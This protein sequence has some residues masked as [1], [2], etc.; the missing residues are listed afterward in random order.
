MTH[1]H[2]LNTAQ[3]LTLAQLDFWE[4]FRL[5]PGEAVSTVAHALELCGPVD[6]DAL[7]RAI[8]TLLAEADVLSLRLSVGPDGAPRQTV[9]PARRPVL[10]RIDLAD[11]PDPMG[12]AMAMM[13]QDL[14]APLDLLDQ[15]ISAQGC[16]GW[17]RIAGSG[18]AGAITSR[19][20]A[21]RW[22]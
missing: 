3:P 11:E 13:R 21:M 4:E 22:G 20:T 10:R 12:R 19:W 18:T 9:D 5:H 16:C 8:R 7:A 6:G 2:S 14:T 17:G 15:P 1:H